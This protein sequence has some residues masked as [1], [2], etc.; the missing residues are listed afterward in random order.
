MHAPLAAAP[1]AEMLCL[2]HSAWAPPF[3]WRILWG[4]VAHV[5][6]AGRGSERRLAPAQRAERRGRRLAM[7]TWRRLQPPRVPHAAA[8]KLPLGGCELDTGAARAGPSQVCMERAAWRPQRG[9]RHTWPR[10]TTLFAAGVAPGRSQEDAGSDPVCRPALAALATAATRLCAAR[11]G[12]PW[13]GAPAPH[14]GIAPLH[15]RLRQGLQP[16]YAPELNGKRG[17]A[18]Q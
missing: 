11:W 14:H 4:T 3:M 10:C 2:L 7:R 17:A 16:A 12:H 6:A 18:R 13:Q 9:R 15:H 8:A 5:R 1:L